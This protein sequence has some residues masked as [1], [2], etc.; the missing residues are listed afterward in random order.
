LKH[1]NASTKE[2]TISTYYLLII[3]SY[4][5]YNSIEFKEYCAE[6]KII[7]LCIPLHLLH[8]LQ[9]L[10]I[11]CFSPLKR[12]YLIKVQDIIAKKDSSGSKASE[13]SRKKTAYYKAIIKDNIYRGFRGAGLVPFNLERVLLKLDVVLR[14][15]TLPP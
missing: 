3:N 9:L 10:N 4:K 12:A 2:R 5:S 11:A 13:Q 7:T 8:L 6:Y 1:F 14:T 15:P